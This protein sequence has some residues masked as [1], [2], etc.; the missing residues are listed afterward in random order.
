M[1]I[2][3]GQ[4]EL[5]GERNGKMK[6]KVMA[7]ALALSMVFSLMPALA[8]G[9]SKNIN[10][11][12]G[13]F[14]NTATNNGITSRR[15]PISSDETTMKWASKGAAEYTN[16]CTPPLV[17]DNY[18]YTA[19]GRYVYKL[20][21]S[22]G[23]KVAT[24]ERLAG[25][26]GYALNPLLYAEGK[27]FI[28]IGEGRVQALDAKTL[29]SLWISEKVGGQTLSPITYKNGY[30]FTGTWNAEE[31]DGVYFGISA[32]DENKNSGT[33]IKKC[34][35]KLIPSK[36]G[37]GNKGFYWAGSYST[38]KFVV[39]GSDDGAEEGNYASG[40]TLYSVNYRDGKVIDKVNDLK[41]D[42]RTTVVHNN[43]YVYFATKGGYLYK[44]VMNNDGTFGKSSFIHLEGMM[45]AAPVIYN[46]RI[47]IGVAGKGGQFDADGGHM[48]AVINDE[49]KLSDSSLAY[50]VNIPGYPQAA[51]LLSTQNAKIDYNKD[52][53]ADG[54]VYLYFT[55]N[56]LPGGIYYITDQ[57]GQTQGRATALFQPPKKQRQYSISTIICDKQGTL[58]YKNDS[59]YLMA[60]AKNKAFAQDIKVTTSKGV[61]TWSEEF[62]SGNLKYTLKIPNAATKV[63]FNLNLPKSTTA[64]IDGKKYKTNHM[65]YIGTSND[66]TVKIKV[67]H[68]KISRTYYLELKKQGITALLSNIFVNTSNIYGQNP[69]DLNVPFNNKILDYKTSEIVGERN[70]VNLW[71]APEDKNMRVSVLPVSGVGNQSIE[72]GEIKTLS[73]AIVNGISNSRYPIYFSEGEKI[74]KVKIKVES[75]DGKIANFYNVDI[76]KN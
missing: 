40:A 55:Y 22:T 1:V 68:N 56:S 71:I 62:S 25:G 8:F 52:G 54:R 6:K 39:F 46:G 35:W 75:E 73:N 70:F 76:L 27:I 2:V 7:S 65:L 74:A 30:V 5:T 64:T 38:E 3:N 50:K 17:L 16:A 11:E 29:K 10:V 33:E 18:I 15:T 47:Y 28:Q 69:V 12:W 43:G 13:S 24:S 59:G 63:V 61:P 44:V 36:E 34:K 26:L 60:V 31:K 37:D 48:F 49:L 19:A 51:A 66:K 23:K 20:S 67:S 42:I 4:E 58:Y 57:P 45:T 32:K 72:D 21:K 41:G 53:K 9:A 14:R